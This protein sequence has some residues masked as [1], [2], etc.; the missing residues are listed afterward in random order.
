MPQLDSEVRPQ[1]K[2]S[3]W[4]QRSNKVDTVVHFAWDARELP[5]WMDYISKLWQ[6]WLWLVVQDKRLEVFRRLQATSKLYLEVSYT[7]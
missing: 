4:G 3:I 6:F 7:V 1:C 5:L 2:C